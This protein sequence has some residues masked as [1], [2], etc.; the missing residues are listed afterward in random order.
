MRVDG[1][2]GE[3][4]D[5]LLDAL[6]RPPASRSSRRGDF[7]AWAAP[8]ELD[9]LSANKPARS[10]CAVRM[11]SVAAMA[12]GPIGHAELQPNDFDGRE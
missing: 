5:D 2:A 7:S 6:R 11:F 8:V 4:A 9:S 3:I 10:G 12:L 1:A